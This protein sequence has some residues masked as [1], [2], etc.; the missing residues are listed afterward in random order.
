MKYGRAPGLARALP[1]V[2]LLAGTA[3]PAA[4]DVFD[5]LSGTFGRPFMADDCR[6]NPHVFRFSPDRS[7]AFVSW[8]QPIFTFRQLWETAAEYEVTGHDEA[9][10]TMRFADETRLAADGRPVVWIMRPVALPE[11]YC[12][13]RTD[14]P[15]ARCEF[16]AVRCGEVPVS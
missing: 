2:L 4:A 12:W 11:G 15:A 7:R 13:G 10:V 5:R 6:N 14:W 1:F 3:G 9:G 16:H 8:E